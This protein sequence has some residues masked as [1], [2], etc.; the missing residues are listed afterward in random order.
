MWLRAGVLFGVAG[1]SVDKRLNTNEL[2]SRFS[3]EVPL[4]LEHKE[5]GP[6][7]LLEQGS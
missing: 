6:L 7:M 4:A 2:A 5:W 3:L 1:H